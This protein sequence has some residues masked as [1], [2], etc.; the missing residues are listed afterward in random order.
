MLKNRKKLPTTKGLQH[1][2]V[3]VGAH[4]VFMY[5]C[6]YVFM[7]ACTSNRGMHDCVIVCMHV[8]MIDKGQTEIHV[9]RVILLER[10]ARSVYVFQRYLCT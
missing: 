8:C 3:Y 5:V 4:C 7:F 6:V 10:A 1:S 2:E 9:A